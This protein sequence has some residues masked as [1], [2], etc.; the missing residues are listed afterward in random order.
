[1]TVIETSPDARIEEAPPDPSLHAAQL[2]LRAWGLLECPAIPFW[3]TPDGKPAVKRITDTA[4]RLT[5]R[6]HTAD[7][8]YGGL[9]TV[10]Y[11]IANQTHSAFEFLYPLPEDALLFSGPAN[12]LALDKPSQF[13]LPWTPVD[14]GY[15]SW[16]D[17]VGLF[18]DTLTKRAAAEN[19]F[20][21]TIANFGLPY[22]LLILKKVDA[23]RCAALASDFGNAWTAENLD[24]LQ[25]AGLVY[26]IDMRIMGSLSPVTRIH[27][28]TGWPEV[29]FT[30]GTVTVLKQDPQSKALTPV[31]IEVST[32]DGRRQAYRAGDKTWL[33]ALQAAKTSITV[34]GIW[35]GH[36]Y[37][38][39]IVTA[40]LQMTMHNQLPPDNRLWTLL[41][42][43]SKSL[44][45]F[46]FNLL[47]TLW[48]KIAPPTPVDGPMSLLPL[49][50]LFSEGREFF[51]DDPLST[52]KRNGLKPG[53]F[54]VHEK[55]DAFPLVG[56]QLDIWKLTQKYVT[57]VVNVLYPTNGEVKN[58]TGLKAWM[59][60]SRD[61]LQG[62]VKGLPKME[63]QADLAA[64]LTS[65]LY[66]I[67]A[68]GAA[69][70][71]PS[72]NPVLSFMANFPPCL[73]TADIPGP[74]DKMS[75]TQLLAHLP[76]TG[77]LGGM[78]TFYYTFAYTPPYKALVPSGGI[79]LD[80]YF[81]PPYQRCNEALFRYRQDIERF[82]DSY[83]NGLNTALHKLWG[84]KPAPP[85]DR[86]D[87]Y[88]QWPP[89][90]EI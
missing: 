66:R 59:D 56:F 77:T 44:I 51:D 14:P 69:S 28:I 55:W 22:N 2:P 17:L 64:V 36:V 73:Q 29:R 49:L 72:V 79:N 27:P 25:K 75:T 70:L 81:P 5:T 90:I 74:T 40:A 37:P 52:I 1:M 61:P 15:K 30:P 19:S 60:A 63:T 4:E 12:E 48:D 45:D 8:E 53:D 10:T 54:T 24:A 86:R 43:Q 13:T 62:N 71:S 9:D 80:P 84:H 67:T 57:K 41:G 85:A 76:H 47:M 21:P 38:W 50:E 89:S 16:Q 83:V 23:R 65:L 82:V 20:W 46:D 34:Y 11:T 68:H 32:K 87:L 42:P 33:W 26:E 7:P 58:D 6:G 39:H 3:A 35:L 18:S 78:T 88:L 31:L